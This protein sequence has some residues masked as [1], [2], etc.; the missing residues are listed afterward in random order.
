VSAPIAILLQPTNNASF[1]T[2]S[3]IQLVASTFDAANLITNVEFYANGV[4][5]GQVSHPPY[6][7]AWS[8]ALAGNYSL[9]AR[10]NCISGIATDSNPIKI[11]AVSLA[12]RLELSARGSGFFLLKGVGSPGQSYQIQARDGLSSASWQTLATVLADSSGVI[13]FTDA[14]ASSQRLYRTVSP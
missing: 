7:F 12:P 4:K 13:S 6:S 8:N 9:V 1:A 2:P 5:L 11:L 14:N 3:N 10:G